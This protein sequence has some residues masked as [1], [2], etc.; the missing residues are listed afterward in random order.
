M[1]V[2]VLGLADTSY[3]SLRPERCQA[4]TEYYYL[5][6]M[7]DYDELCELGLIYPPVWQA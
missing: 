4:L 7:H 3:N 5:N 6:N 1:G 2:N